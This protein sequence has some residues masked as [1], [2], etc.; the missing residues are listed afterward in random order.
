MRLKKKKENNFVNGIILIHVGKWFYRYL[1]R[2]GN[3]TL[4]TVGYP[5]GIKLFS[6]KVFFSTYNLRSAQKHYL[7]GLIH[8]VYTVSV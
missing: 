1:S 6:T 7:I 5:I 8:D 4:E 3:S 2:R